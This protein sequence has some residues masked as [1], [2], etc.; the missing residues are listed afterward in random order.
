V[1]KSSFYEAFLVK[2]SS[3][4]GAFDVKSRPFIRHFWCEKNVI[5]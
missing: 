5:L 4:Y 3:F 1:K 2:K